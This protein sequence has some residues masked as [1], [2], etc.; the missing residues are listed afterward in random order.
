MPKNFYSQAEKDDMKLKKSKQVLYSYKKEKEKV[1]EAKQYW[2][3]RKLPDKTIL[4]SAIEIKWFEAMAK[5]HKEMSAIQFLSTYST[6]WTTVQKIF[7]AKRQTYKDIHQPTEEEIDKVVKVHSVSFFETKYLKLN[8]KEKEIFL[9]YG[10]KILNAEYINLS[11]SEFQEMYPM[12]YDSMIL[13]FGNKIKQ[14]PH[15]YVDNSRMSFLKKQWDINAK[16]N[17][18]YFKRQQ[19]ENSFFSKMHS[20]TITFPFVR[21]T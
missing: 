19:L 1:E 6:T 8:Q 20:S 17:A 15:L 18:E 13:L 11:I 10:H 12:R 14:N 2:K 5:E 16:A 7:W 3:S 4:E 21:G 9:K